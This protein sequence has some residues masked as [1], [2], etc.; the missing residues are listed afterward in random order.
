MAALDAEELV[1]RLQALETGMEARFTALTEQVNRGQHAIEQLTVR[2]A[3]E[4]EARGICFLDPRR[5]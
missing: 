2:L 4:Q 5:R 1:R 3:G